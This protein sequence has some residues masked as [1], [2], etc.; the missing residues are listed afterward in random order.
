MRFLSAL[1]PLGTRPD[2][3]FCHEVAK[4]LRERGHT[5]RL[6]YFNRPPTPEEDAWLRRAQLDWTLCER[7][8]NA[9]RQVVAL[10]RELHAFR[11]DVAEFHFSSTTPGL[12]ATAFCRVPVRVAWYHSSI[13]YGREI[14]PGS[15]L[16]LALHLQGERLARRLATHH[17]TLS[18]TSREE[19]LQWY[20]IPAG[21]VSVHPLGIDLETVT[22]AHAA[23]A[24]MAAGMPGPLLLCAG[25]LTEAKGQTILVSCLPELLRRVPQLTL[26]LAG[27]GDSSALMAQARKLR[28][29][30]HCHFV[31]E[32]TRPEFLGCLQRATVLLAPS[33]A[34]AFGL[35][36]LE[37]MAAGVPVLAAP[38]GVAADVIRSG[39]NGLL[40]ANAGPAAWAQALATALG[41]ATLRQRWAGA[42]RGT[43]AGFGMDE[44]VNGYANWLEQ[45]DKSCTS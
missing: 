39:S 7:R 43:V 17:V 30:E 35:V 3:R 18:S 15:A 8:G 41:D 23:P 4:R 11:P 16:A 1:P 9:V 44:R 12:L 21:R 13:V 6:V 33:R 20:R 25:R 37:A 24:W 32:L 31:G 5:V 45:E 22:A 38:V 2:S 28:V 26:V 14:F 36:V 34:E 10:G 29:Q 27:P 19:Y 42:A 40:L